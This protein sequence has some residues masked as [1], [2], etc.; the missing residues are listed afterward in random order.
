MSAAT[1][2]SFSWSL[3]QSPP[4]AHFVVH[5]VAH[6]VEFRP[7]FPDKVRHGTTLVRAIIA[8]YL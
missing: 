3:S 7:V 8:G 4:F 5:F 1:F 6:F 2:A